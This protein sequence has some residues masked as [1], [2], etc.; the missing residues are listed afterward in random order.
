MSPK[1]VNEKNKINNDVNSANYGVI[2]LNFFQ[3]MTDLDQ[4]KIQISDASTVILT[5]WWIKIF[6]L[7]ETQNRTKKVVTQLFYC[8]FA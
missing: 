6:N 1:H 5:V 4:S 7:T 8:Y 3:F 2:V